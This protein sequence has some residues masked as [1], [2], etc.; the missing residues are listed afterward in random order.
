MQHLFLKVSIF[1]IFS[2]IFAFC[3]IGQE[4]EMVRLPEPQTSG[5]KPLMEA[6]KERESSRSFSSAELSKQQLSDL[7]WAAF[8]IS[9]PESGLRTAPSAMNTQDIDIYVVMAEGWYLYDHESHALVLKGK[10]DIREFTGLQEFVK[11]APVNLV[12][13][14]D[15][16]KLS[17]RM[18]EDTKKFY[19]SN[20]AGYISQNVYLYCA[21]EGLATVVRGA[22]DRDKIHKTLNLEDHQHVIFAQTVGYPG[23]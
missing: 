3:I 18:D 15:F 2:F 5:G 10:S 11:T 14:S 19:A 21:S 20:H 12:F 17:D 22:I 13:V 1:F 9:R 16:T 8:G 23:E 7:L 6:L 4:E